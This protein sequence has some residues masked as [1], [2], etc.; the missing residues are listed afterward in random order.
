[1]SILLN[2]GKSNGSCKRNPVADEFLVI[3][4]QKNLIWNKVFIHIPSFFRY[5]IHHLKINASQVI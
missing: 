1:M 3:M 2:Y 4:K 5:R